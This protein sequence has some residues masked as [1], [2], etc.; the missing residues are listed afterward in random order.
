MTY[1]YYEEDALLCQRQLDLIGDD[2]HDIGITSVLACSFLCLRAR[3]DAMRD[4]S[5][6]VPTSDFLQPS[7]LRLGLAL[8]VMRMYLYQFIF[9]PQLFDDDAI[10]ILRRYLHISAFLRKELERVNTEQLHL[11]M[12]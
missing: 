1:G 10:Q 7:R 12:L 3:E 11:R 9:F 4:V 6:S 8:S 2:R 5:D